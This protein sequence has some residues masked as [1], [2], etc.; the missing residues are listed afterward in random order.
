MH[1]WPCRI[2]CRPIHG[3]STCHRPFHSEC[4]NLDLVPWAITLACVLT[5][6]FGPIG[7]YRGEQYG[8][9][10]SCKVYLITPNI[11]DLCPFLPVL[12]DNEA[13]KQRLIW[14]TIFEKNEKYFQINIQHTHVKYLQFLY[15]AIQEDDNDYKATEVD[16]CFSR[17]RFPTSGRRS[18]V[19]SL[20]RSGTRRDL[21]QWP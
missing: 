15:A 9:R 17:T 11:L 13:Q 14:L 7:D 12:G 16:V 5:F 3:R 19:T 10:I 2:V 6:G 4:L 18:R 21:G 20:S 1:W 8:L